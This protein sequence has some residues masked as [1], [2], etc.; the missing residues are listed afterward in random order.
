MP[1]ARKKSK[2]RPIPVTC[3]C[4]TGK[5]YAECCGPLHEGARTAD[6]PVSLMRSRYSAFCLG[7]GEYLWN[8]LHSQ[9]EARA[10]DHDAYCA[11]VKRGAQSNAYRALRVIDSRPAD[12][13]GVA[14]VL[15]YAQAAVGKLDRSIVELSSFVQ[16]DGQW[17]Y[18]AG[19]TRAAR[20][21]SHGPDELS[22]EHWDCA[23]HH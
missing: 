1:K 6:D 9:H 17:R 12:V 19:I 5:P 15:F 21:L 10:G 4:G 11:E 3:L 7:K 20:S 14:Q 22:I 8:T 16:E 23:H 18:I 13:S 2:V